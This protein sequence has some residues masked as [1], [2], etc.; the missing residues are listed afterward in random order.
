VVEVSA[1]SRFGLKRVGFHII[2]SKRTLMMTANLSSDVD[3]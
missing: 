2:E 3:D 1:S